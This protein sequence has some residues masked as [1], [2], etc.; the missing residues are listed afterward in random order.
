MKL[1]NLFTI[2]ILTSTL[3]FTSCT[4]RLTPKGAAVRVIDS[5]FAK[6]CRYIGAFSSTTGSGSQNKVLNHLKNQ[7]AQAGGNAFV[8]SA[9]SSSSFYQRYSIAA[10]AY[11]CN[12]HKVKS[13][14]TKT[15]TTLLERLRTLKRLH[16]EKLLTDDEYNSKKEKIINEI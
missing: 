8:V 1:H 6:E 14:E 12:F 2:S 7:I 5:T 15:D 13:T 11:K 9:E 4:V 16:Q 3:F 10:D